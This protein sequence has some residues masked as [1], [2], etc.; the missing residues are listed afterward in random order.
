MPIEFEW[1]GAGGP[2]HDCIENVSSLVHAGGGVF[3]A[4]MAF[5][6]MDSD[7]VD[8]T[9]GFDDES[10]GSDSAD[11]AIVFAEHAN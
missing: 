4:T 11:S 3:N 1:D 8:C 2:T 10:P 7:L 9:T 6:L 5:M